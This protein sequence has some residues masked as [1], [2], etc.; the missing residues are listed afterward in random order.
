MPPVHISQIT[1]TQ[2]YGIP[3]VE[4]WDIGEKTG[5]PKRWKARCHECGEPI[6]QHQID[7]AYMELL[8]KER[9]KAHA[10]MVKEFGPEMRIP[11]ECAGC[12]RTLIQLAVKN[13]RVFYSTPPNYFSRNPGKGVNDSWLYGE[14]EKVE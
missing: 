14:K 5:Q 9:P 7:P 3:A 1:P 10:L 8:E 12:A 2:P 4:C 13:D 11:R 6:V